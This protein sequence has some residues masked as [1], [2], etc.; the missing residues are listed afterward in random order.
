MKIPKIILLILASG[1]IVGLGVLVFGAIS[2]KTSKSPIIN[3]LPIPTENPAPTD[4]TSDAG[5]LDFGK[6]ISFKLNDKFTFIDGLEVMLKEINDSRC[7]QGR[8]CVWMGEISGLFVLSGGT[9]VTPKE[10]RLGT[11]NNSSVSWEGYTFSLQDAT[12]DNLN[13]QV[14]KN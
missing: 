13:I 6:T 14:T 5:F 4:T 9:L 3:K 11:V 7:P 2:T 12:E 1:F 10:L 8:V